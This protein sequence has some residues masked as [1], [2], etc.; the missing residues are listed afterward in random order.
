MVVRLYLIGK[1]QSLL[2]LYFFNILTNVVEV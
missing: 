2:S 1:D